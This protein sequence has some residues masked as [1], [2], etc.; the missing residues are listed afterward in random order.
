MWHQHKYPKSVSLTGARELSA[1][2]IVEFNA[3]VEAARQRLQTA[4]GLAESFRD[5]PRETPGHSRTAA[6]L[7][8]SA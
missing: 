1:E 2:K 8:G 6:R 4:D 5:T 3:I 7:E